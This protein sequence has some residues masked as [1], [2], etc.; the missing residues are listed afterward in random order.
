MG[1]L[2]ATT[3]AAAIAAMPSLRDVLQVV[4]GEST[5]LRRQLGAPA[6]GVS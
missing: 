6:R 1:R 3:P 5:H 4:C 2:T